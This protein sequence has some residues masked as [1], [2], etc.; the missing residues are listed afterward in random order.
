LSAGKEKVRKG[1]G[2]RA[3]EKDQ[4]VEVGNEDWVSEVGSSEIGCSRMSK[5]S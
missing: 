2:S 1:R 3:G 5:E 4:S